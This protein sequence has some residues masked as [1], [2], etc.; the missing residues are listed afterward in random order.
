M[1]T[2]HII[3]GAIILIAVCVGIYFLA[4]S[5]NQMGPETIPAL[6]GEIS[7]DV[8]KVFANTDPGLQP[9]AMP[10]G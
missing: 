7:A 3:I 1:K 9:P 2:E 6:P 10:L 5:G 4:T 8:V